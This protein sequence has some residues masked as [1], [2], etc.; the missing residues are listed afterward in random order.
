MTTNVTA[1]GDRKRP[2]TLDRRAASS[3]VRAVTPRQKLLDAQ[4]WGTLQANL[5]LYAHKR[6]GRRSM[7]EARDLAASAIAGLLKRP[8][9]W[10]PEKE[11]LF[12]HLAKR[13]IGVAHN[14]WRHKRNQF[15]VRMRGR[16]EAAALEVGDDQDSLDDVLDRRRLA[17][18]A[19]A[20]IEAR[21][22]GKPN[23]LAVVALM[24]EGL[25][26][27]LAQQKASG[28]SLAE[29]RDAR[30]V[31]FYHAEIVAKEMGDAIERGDSVSDDEPDDDTDFNDD[32]DASL[33]DRDGDA[34]VDLDDEEV[35]Q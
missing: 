32:S 16:V 9:S 23:A 3:T 29:L 12:K 20:L 35:A 6:I 8:E 30:R 26:T 19:C 17:L 5:A 10:D 28:L 14:E 7:E 27:P 4:D 2:A 33:S 21:L 1:I 25:D 34:E 13:V 24:K 15:E 22:A 11:H 18:R 31:V